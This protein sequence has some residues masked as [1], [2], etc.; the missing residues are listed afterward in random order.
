MERIKGKHRVYFKLIIIA[1]LLVIVLLGYANIVIYNKYLEEI[2]INK[3]L[4]INSKNI[5][6]KYTR[7]K[8]EINNLTKQIEEL[9]NIDNNLSKTKEDVFI[10]STLLEKKIVAKQVNKKIAYLTFDDGPYHSTNRVLYILK[11]NKVKATFFTI[12]L[13]KDTCYDNSNYSCYD[14]YKKIVDNGH[15]I[16]NHTYS[17]LIFDGLYNSADSFINQVK[18]QEELIKERTGIITNIVRFP[19]GS[20]T[21]KHY[22][23]KDSAINKLRE[24][25]YGWVD[26]SATDGDGGYIANATLAWNNLKNTI[27]ED[28]EVILFHDY[29]NITITILPDAIAYLKDNNYIILPLFYDSIKVNK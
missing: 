15:T 23:I 21:A 27:N 17:H 5:N 13:N 26:W 1:Y 19:G 3:K 6:N 18:I 14:I 16:A 4:I 12:G 11:E 7:S 24:N 9:K 28:I 10:L 29:N 8:K 25:N 20:G 2:D 22:G